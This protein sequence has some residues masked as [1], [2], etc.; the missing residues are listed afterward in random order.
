MSEWAAYSESATDYLPKS[1]IL[2]QLA[3]EACELAQAAL[4]LRRKIDGINP[5]PVSM[6]D[7]A[8]N[9]IEEFTDVIHCAL[10]LGIDYEPAILYQKHKRWIERLRARPA[11]SGKVGGGDA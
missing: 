7:A 6:D 1:E 5:T 2:A 11:K 10:E 3:E 9:L 4:K 8:E